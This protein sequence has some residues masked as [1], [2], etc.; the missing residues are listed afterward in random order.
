MYQNE[1]LLQING[2]RCRT[3][4]FSALQW[5]VDL[6]TKPW[7]YLHNSGRLHDN[8]RTIQG[9]VNCCNGLL[10]PFTI[11]VPKKNI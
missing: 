1:F 7:I 6:G 5:I 11:G 4:D 9:L 2:F 3:M 10:G 8:Q